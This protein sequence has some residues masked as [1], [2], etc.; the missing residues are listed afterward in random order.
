MLW[1]IPCSHRPPWE[2]SSRDPLL[3]T[4]TNELFYSRKEGNAGSVT[5]LPACLSHRNPEHAAR[6]QESKAMVRLAHQCSCV[7]GEDKTSPIYLYHRPTARFCLQ[8]LRQEARE[9][10][11]ARR[12]ADPCCNVRCANIS[13]TKDVSCIHL[14]SR[15]MCSH[16]QN[17]FRY[18]NSRQVLNYGARSKC[19]DPKHWNYILN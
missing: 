16:V 10:S 17:C 1:I 3:F 19:M 6:V 13:A 14:P 2:A 7:R 18:A 8:F 12:L 5:V 9:I 4:G 11:T 15:N